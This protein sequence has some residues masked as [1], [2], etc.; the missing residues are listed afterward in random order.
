MAPVRGR[1][2]GRSMTYLCLSHHLLWLCPLRDLCQRMI[3]VDPAIGS[4]MLCPG[5]AA[6]RREGARHAVHFAGRLS[7]YSK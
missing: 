7:Q 4:P 1:A 6:R 2:H 3:I 5:R